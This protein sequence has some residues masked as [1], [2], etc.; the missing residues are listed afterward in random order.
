MYL[1]INVTLPCV[2]RGLHKLVISYT[3]TEYPAQN[4]IRLLIMHQYINYYVH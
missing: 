4:Y 3:F 2:C 1:W